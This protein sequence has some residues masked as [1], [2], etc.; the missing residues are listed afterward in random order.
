MK[1]GQDHV[2]PLATQAVA[3]LR[4]LYAMTGHGKFVFP[5]VRTST[6]CMSEN[7]VNAALRGMATA[8]T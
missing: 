8:R 6:R 3:L 1:M 5:S 7:T 4:D 2:M